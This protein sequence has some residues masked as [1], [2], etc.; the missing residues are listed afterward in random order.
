MASQTSL[1]VSATEFK[2]GM[3]THTTLANVVLPV[4]TDTTV[5]ECDGKT[6]LQLK[7]QAVST[8]TDAVKSAGT[9]SNCC[10]DIASVTT[11]SLQTF[12][13]V[14]GDVNQKRRKLYFLEQGNEV[15]KQFNVCSQQKTC[16]GECGFPHKPKADGSV[17]EI[18]A[19][20]KNKYV[21][22]VVMQPEL[23]A[24]LTKNYSGD[25]KT[26]ANSTV[27]DLK[28]AGGDRDSLC[29]FNASVA[30]ICGE[31]NANIVSISTCL[32]FT[33][34]LSQKILDLTKENS[35]LDADIKQA[36]QEKF[37]LRKSLTS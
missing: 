24:I 9:L 19:M 7:D 4:Q 8:L 30:A 22:N 13:T 33:K 37:R 31:V 25:I 5:L 28:K 23:F 16:N 1:S 27:S 21:N 36:N 3:P 29:A 34:T 12:E 11:T 32:K 15:I 26:I 10:R 2:E 18:P 6:L 14:R 20:P 35:K 17:P